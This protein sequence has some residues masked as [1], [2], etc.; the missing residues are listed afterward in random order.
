MP[1]RNIFFESGD[2]MDHNLPNR[3]DLRIKN[4]DYSQAGYYF[5][6]ICTEGKCM[7]WGMLLMGLWN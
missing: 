6:T 5:V 4:Y 2:T 1:A 7:H 3:K